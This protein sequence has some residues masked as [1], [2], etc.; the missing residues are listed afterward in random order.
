MVSD[1]MDNTPGTMMVA[2]ESVSR[3]WDRI[4]WAS[5]WA[6]RMASWDVCSGVGTGCE[7]GRLGGP[8]REENHD[9]SAGTGG[10][11]VQGVVDSTSSKNPE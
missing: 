5:S 10:E 6:S 9:I 2:D 1:T 8:N 7:G 11:G 3:W 4:R